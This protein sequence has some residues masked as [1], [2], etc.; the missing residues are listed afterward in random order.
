MILLLSSCGGKKNEVIMRE[1]AVET[2]TITSSVSATGSVTPRNRLVLMPTVAGRIDEMLFNEGDAVKAGDVLAWMSSSDRAA[3]ID[4]ARLKGEAELRYWSET[5][6]RIP[7]VA[8]VAGTIIVRGV[9]PGQSVTT[10]S[11]VYVISDTL[12]VATS[13]DETDIGRVAVGLRS[14]FTLDAHPDRSVEGSVTHISYESTLTNNVNMYTV[15][16][17]PLQ[18]EPLLRSG[19]TAT[20]NIIIEQHDDA[21]ILPSEAVQNDNGKNFVFVKIL[22][23]GSP[24]ELRPVET[25]I[26]NDTQIE[27]TRGLK[28]GD[29]AVLIST[30]T[31]GSSSSSSGNAKKEE[32]SKNPFMPTPPKGM[33]RGAGGPPDG[34]PR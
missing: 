21:I 1:I 16:V 20:V 2:G 3:L 22:N 29:M 5:Y 23:Q 24:P 10:S 13:V 27:I 32:K 19:M 34:G 31:Q 8:P 25:G 30:D 11:E 12:V 26:T 14:T 4:A 6:R 17:T 18:A 7:I 33:K 15:Q 28:S 9:E